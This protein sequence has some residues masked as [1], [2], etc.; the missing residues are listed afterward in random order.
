MVENLSKNLADSDEYP[1]MLD[2]H[3]RCVGM[4]ANLW[5]VQTG[6]KAIGSATTGSSEAIHLG[7]L[8]MKQLWKEKRQAAGKDTSKP[9]ILMGANAQVALEKFARYFDVE[10]RILPVSKDSRYVLDT[11][12]IRQNV[13]ENT[14]GVFV[15]LGSTYTGVYE[16]VEEVSNILDAYEAESGNYIPI[17]VDGASGAFVAPFTH[18]EAGFK[19]NFEVPRVHSIN[20]SGH[21]FGLVYPGVGWIIWRDEKYLPKHLIFELRYLGGVEESFTLNFSRPGAQIIAQYYNLIHLGRKGYRDVMEHVLMNARILSDALEATG[22]YRCVSDIHRKRGDYAYTGAT[23]AFQ[24][25]D[26]SEAYNPGLP[27][28]AFCF[29][30]DFKKAHPRLKQD[31]VSQILRVKGYI[32]PSE[33]LF[34]PGSLEFCLNPTKRKSQGANQKNNFQTT[35]YPRMRRGRRF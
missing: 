24:G 6:E 2:I 17:H 1:A 9:N 20:T 23:T 11:S 35:P 33:Y 10:A 27:V 29:T 21:K 16:N 13:D 14:I 15:I 4:L 5:K 28:V 8:A 7:G 26:T 19:W 18:A 22:W 32:V 3:S 30:D 12:L 25:G 31:A 34:L